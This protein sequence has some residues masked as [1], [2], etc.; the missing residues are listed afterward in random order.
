MSGGGYIGAWLVGNVR[1]RPAWLGKAADWQESI[2]YLRRYA[3]YLTPKVGLL[4][5][6]TWNMG[7]T[8]SRNIILL[9]IPLY[10]SIAMAL[11]LP[12]VAVRVFQH[13]ASDAGGPHALVGS[14]IQVTQVATY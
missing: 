3:N 13:W 1:R 14:D 6:D 5:A 7:M 9:Q 12:Y 11:M 8:W 2:R 4:S 10:L